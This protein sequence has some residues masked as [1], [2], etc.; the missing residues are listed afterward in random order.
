M[1]W[2]TIVGILLVV[3]GV[4]GL[5]IGGIQYTEEEAG[6]EA[7]PLEVRVEERRTIPIPPV[8]G[9]VALVAGAGF[10]YVGLRGRG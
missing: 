10:L 4:A 6:V 5:L 1:R 3:V 9:A 8:L 7:G 2:E